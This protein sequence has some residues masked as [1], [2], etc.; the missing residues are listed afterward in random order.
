[1]DSYHDEMT[2][3]I[4]LRVFYARCFI[5]AMTRYIE[6][7]TPH[8]T[9]G[10]KKLND[11]L[12]DMNMINDH[13]KE[14]VNEV[15]GEFDM[16]SIGLM[17]KNWGKLYDVLWKYHNYK[18]QLLDEKAKKLLIPAALE[19]DETELAEINE[20]LGLGV[21]E[22]F[23][24]HKA[25]IDSFYGTEPPPQTTDPVM[26]QYINIQNMNGIMAGV[27]NGNM[28]QNNNKELLDALKELAEL[29]IKTNVT[30]QVT[31]EALQNIKD[32]QAEALNPYPNK[33]KIQKAVEGLQV[34]TNFT[35]LTAFIIQV[36][37]LLHTVQQCVAHIK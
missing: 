3:H 17:G 7:L 1:M 22:K 10:T 19:G 26:Q 9:T 33:T 21:W 37:P 15:D 36:T 16:V 25:L 30:D 2:K 32:I 5:A 18:K 28:V 35:Q 14:K 20:V 23:T 12:A 11:E 4:Q 31:A 34:L 6:L 13:F 29:L 24:R 27:N 8:K